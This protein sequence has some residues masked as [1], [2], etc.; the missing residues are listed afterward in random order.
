MRFGRRYE[1]REEQREL[2]AAERRES[3][4]NILEKTA[5]VLFFGMLFL[6]V[7]IWQEQHMPEELSAKVLRFHVLANSDSEA[8]QEL[9]TWTRASGC[10]SSHRARAWSAAWMR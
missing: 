4:W 1:N 6:G 5:V 2:S 7:Y 3:R 9:N 10:S 8:D